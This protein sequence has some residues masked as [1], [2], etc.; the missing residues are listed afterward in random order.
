MAAQAPSLPGQP[1]CGRGDAIVLQKAMS[2]KEE[3]PLVTLRDGIGS[4]ANGCKL[5]V[6]KSH[7][8]MGRKCTDGAD[9]TDGGK[10]RLWRS[11][12]DQEQKA[13]LHRRSDM[14][15]VFVHYHIPSLITGSSTARLLLITQEVL[16]NPAFLHFARDIFISSLSSCHRLY[17]H[18][19]P[20]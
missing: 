14:A 4:R 8:E 6:N 9:H 1:R 17:V 20:C 18:F 7:Q 16:S 3:E 13:E 2:K 15:V 19:L 10:R 5:A 11:P 12:A